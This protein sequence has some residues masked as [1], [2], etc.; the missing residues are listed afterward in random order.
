MITLSPAAPG[1]S[2]CMKSVSASTASAIEAATTT[3]LPA[4]RPSALTTMGGF[5]CST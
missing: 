3:P 4:A 2:S 1:S 5:C